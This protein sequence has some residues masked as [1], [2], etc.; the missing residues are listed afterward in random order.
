MSFTW[1]RP[2]ESGWSIGATPDR[3]T[4]LVLDHAAN[5]QASLPARLSRQSDTPTSGVGRRLR[6]W[7]WSRH[8]PAIAVGRPV[9]VTL[10]DG[11]MGT[12]QDG[13][14]KA[15]RRRAKAGAIGLRGR[16]YTLEHLN[17]REAILFRDGTE[18]VRLRRPRWGRH[19]GNPVSRSFAPGVEGV[20]DHTDLLALTISER[21]LEPGRSGAVGSILSSGGI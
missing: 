16:R 19:P 21:L 9:P 12:V 11:G 2:T 13:H 1:Q 10:P 6:E 20:L 14:P 5:V 7:E 4:I 15:I 3:Q 8:G 18:L 17:R